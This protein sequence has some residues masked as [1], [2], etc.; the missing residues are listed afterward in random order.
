MPRRCG[1]AAHA[2]WAAL[3]FAALL[4]ASCHTS[5]SSVEAFA[6]G[7]AGPRSGSSLRSLRSSPASSVDETVSIQQPFAPPAHSV[8][9][10]S[11]PSRNDKFAPGESL[12]R[13][14]WRWKDAKLGD[15]RDYF[16]PRPRALKAFH[17]LFVGMELSL[18]NEGGL[19]ELQMNLPPREETE[20][21]LVRQ[22]VHRGSQESSVFGSYQYSIEECVALSN[23]ARLDVILVLRR[24]T[25]IGAYGNGS[26]KMAQMAARF[27]VAYNLQQ[28]VS[29]RRSNSESLLERA[30][31]ASWLDLPGAVQQTPSGGSNEEERTTEVNQ[32]AERLTG[33]HEIDSISR[34]LCLIAGGLAPRPSRPGR[35]VIFRPYSSRDAHVLLQLK[36]T[37][38]VVSVD[39]SDY[40]KGRV[41]TLL[42][43]ALRA[44]KAARNEAVVPEIRELKQYGSDGT[45]PSKIANVVAGAAIQKAVDPSVKTCVSKLQAMESGTPSLIVI[46][47]ERVNKLAASF[48]NPD[49]RKLANRL[50]HEPTMRL[51]AG[52]LTSDDIDSVVSQIESRLRDDF[53]VS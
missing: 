38:E 22:P 27:A 51:R 20:G 14:C 13:E 12:V 48:E 47:R 32:L 45:P 30:G 6:P 52:E 1:P 31:I 19:I 29:S 21:A 28:Q 34:H 23:C 24:Q 7:G 11:L 9:L 39:S 42:D 49:V 2:W 37:V 16:V 4:V 53:P 41:K 8:H 26:D 5:S 44:G 46:L 35:E 25:E 50:L 10:V 15:G 33:F 40:P 36:R 18:S 3:A 17:D 43:T